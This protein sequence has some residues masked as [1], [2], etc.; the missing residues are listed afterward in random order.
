[1]HTETLLL[2]LMLAISFVLLIVHIS[3]QSNLSS[4]CQMTQQLAPVVPAAGTSIVP[5][6]FVKSC[7]VVVDNSDGSH[8]KE[9]MVFHSFD[10]YACT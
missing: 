2:V 1:M 10:I 9:H 5:T 7:E 3:K 4:V 6:N 8:I